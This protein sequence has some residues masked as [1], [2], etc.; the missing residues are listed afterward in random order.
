MTH[1]RLDGHP[2][3]RVRVEQLGDYKLRPTRN[4]IGE[5][6]VTAADLLVHG[7]E[8]RVVEREVTGEKEKQNDPTRPRVGLGA[9][10]SF[11]AA[12]EYF[13][14]GVGR[15]AAG[16]VEEQIAGGTVEV[17]QGGEAEVGYF[18]G[19]VVVQEEV[20]GF[21]VAVGDAVAVAEMEG[22]D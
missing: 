9:V 12:A 14:R 3:V 2:R 18:E 21:Y 6:I 5:L 22:A 17:G 1:Q 15:C 7:G 4:P 16:R 19:P 20:L 10:V 8:I 13:R 11:A